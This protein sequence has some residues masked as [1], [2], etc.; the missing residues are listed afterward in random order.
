MGRAVAL[1]SSKA[2]I[3]LGPS[4]KSCLGNNIIIPFSGDYKAMNCDIA[5]PK[6]LLKKWTMRI[7][8][9]RQVCYGLTIMIAKASLEIKKEMLSVKI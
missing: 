2:A 5:L 9:S 8:E 6:W 4:F 7:H 1:Q 3:L